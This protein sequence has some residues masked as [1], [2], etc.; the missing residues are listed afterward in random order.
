ME[1]P[2]KF[3]CKDCDYTTSRSNDFERHQ[4]SRKHKS[5]Q[6]PQNFVAQFCVDVGSNEISSEN[7]D[8]LVSLIVRDKK[9]TSATKSCGVKKSNEF[10]PDDNG[11][12]Q[13][14]V[15]NGQ[16]MSNFDGQVFQCEMCN[17]TSTRLDAFSRHCES[18]KH[19]KKQDCVK[20]Q[21]TCNKCQKSY[22]SRS[23]L[24]KHIPVCHV[25]IV[26]NTNTD[27]TISQKMF[28]EFVG[29]MMRER[30]ETFKDFVL[31]VM[32]TTQVT[33]S[34]AAT[35]NTNNSHNNTVINNTIDNSQNATFNISVFLNETCKDALNLSEFIQGIKI[36]LSDIEKIGQ[37]GYVNGLSDLIVRNLKEVGVEKRPIHCTDSKRE[38]LYVKEANEWTK[39][40]KAREW[41]QSLVDQVQRLNLRKLPLWREKHPSCLQ[42]KSLYTDMYNNM[43]QE[44]MGGDCK[45]V[46]LCDKD[47]K[48]IKKIT[49]EMFINKDDYKR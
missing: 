45:K 35:I 30:D 42:S 7:A 41:M 39:E 22:L 18:A 19:K 1:N 8:E 21:Y 47:M 16:K 31:E 40:E 28:L 27:T 3:Y 20:P 44:L 43:S 11:V 48:I 15:Q 10:L 9:C 25:D 2:Q 49:K 26:Q 36:E 38:T 12:S 24:H 6:T 29:N 34:T 33:T 23:G 32:K 14:N 17:Y 13:K 5:V 46:R 37:L 4:L